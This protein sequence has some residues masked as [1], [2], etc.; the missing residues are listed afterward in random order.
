MSVSS[1][2]RSWSRSTGRV[3][4]GNGY[5]FQASFSEGWQVLHAVDTLPTDIITAAVLAT[6]DTYPGTYVPRKG[7]GAV[8]RLGPIYTIVT[9]DYEGEVGPN[10]IDD[11]PTNK[12]PEPV[13]ADNS[14]ESAIDEDWNGNPIVT[15]NG[16]SIHGVM[17]EIADQSLTI[18]RNYTFFSPWLTH[19]YRHS[20]NSDIFYS[21]APGTARLVGFSANPQRFRL[22]DYWEVEA[23][24]QF[25]YPF[26]TTPDRAWYARVLHQGLMVKGA[27]GK[28]TRAIDQK[29][30][31]ETA[32]PVL[33]KIDGTAETNPA[34][35]VW[36]EFQRYGSLPY[37]ALG[38]L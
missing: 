24:I 4:T 6:P 18:K 33:L 12:I 21:Y 3:S 31:N 19:E 36:L 34:N 29:T 25:R 16:E 7:I 13:W 14:S 23:T 20:T 30:K 11:H 10:A 5:T 17:M 32:V 1:V 37:A 9:I 8:N 22:A 38:L 27:D 15:A 28:I 2:T 26:R 35:A